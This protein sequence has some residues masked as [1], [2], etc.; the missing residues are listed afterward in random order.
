MKKKAQHRGPILVPLAGSDL[1]ERALAYA[2]LLARIDDAD[3]LT[4]SVSHPD[5]ASLLV[6]KKLAVQVARVE[7]EYLDRYL[8]DL[9]NRQTGQDVT[10]Q[11]E[12]RSGS[13]VEEILNTLN[14]SDARYLVLSTHGRAGLDRWRYGSV[15][16]RLI[17]QAAVPT[18]VV[19]P[20]VLEARGGHEKFERI[21]VPLD[22]SKLS[23]AALAPASVLANKL[24]AS[25]VLARGVPWAA[26]VY[27]SFDPITLNHE[28]DVA[29][30]AY[31]KGVQERT[32]GVT[33]THALRG[34]PAEAL[35]QFVTD[36]KIDLVVMTSHTRA[37]AARA[38]LGS[39]ADRMLQCAAPVLLIRPQDEVRS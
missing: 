20:R 4:V 36:S 1:S 11:S 25:L 9:R 3:V 6:G 5:A 10:I 7:E 28:L 8:E 24:G 22:G 27:P 31:L 39:V 17:R 30:A 32:P 21:L 12:L 35:I 16:G 34:Y 13:P 18:L 29:S 2:L 26:Q 14:E 23:E 33:E 37:G 38:V 19:G 15:A